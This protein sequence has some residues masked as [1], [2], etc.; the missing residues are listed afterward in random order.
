MMKWLSFGNGLLRPACASFKDSVAD[1]EFYDNGFDALNEFLSPEAGRIA[2]QETIMQF[3]VKFCGYTAAESDTV[4]RA[5]AKKKG[6]EKLLPEI[7]ER[8][9]SYSTERYNITHEK[10]EEVIKPFL[11][12]I[13]DA[14]EY[15]F[16]WN[17]SDAY[18]CIGY[19]SGYLRYY[20][21]LEF[22]TAALNIFSD[23]AAKTAE[24]TKYASRNGVKITNPKWGI[25][26]GDY[27]YDNKQKI[28]AKGLKSVKYMSENVAEELYNLAQNNVY[29]SFI[30]LLMDLKHTSINSRQLDILVKIDFFSC[31][32]N[33]R[34]LLRIIDLFTETFNDG[35]AK[36]IAKSKIEGTPLEAIV[37]KYSVGTT[38]SGGIA[39]SYTLFDIQSTMRECEKAI[40]AARMEDLS[41]I[42]KVRNFADIMGYVGYVS[43]K[44]EDRRKLYVIDTYPLVRKSD[45]KQFGYSVVTKSIGSGKESRFTVV[46]KVYDNEPVKK[47][48]IIF[49]R[50][51]EKNGEYYR[52]TSYEKIY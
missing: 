6:T 35:N 51:Y 13:L 44:E 5:I 40:K 10:A 14:S 1:G 30:D 23:N 7:K 50:A 26:K 33:Q 22:L 19:I 27:H 9:I 42:I 48:D 28:I 43:E 15:G 11:K 46:N 32:G 25:S 16:S 34:E 2:M 17:H 18:S 47:G 12:I 36:K 29:E 45:N 31:F 20:Y 37:S 49:C 4:R 3:L 38:K 21:P 24:I 41:D 39:K 8:F 52:L